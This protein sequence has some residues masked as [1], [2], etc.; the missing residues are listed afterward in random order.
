MSSDEGSAK[1]IKGRRNKHKNYKSIEV[2]KEKEIITV[3]RNVL[4]NFLL[5]VKHWLQHNKEL[6]RKAVFI[7]AGSLVVFLVLLIIHALAKDA[8]GLQLI[9]LKNDLEKT[10][11]LPEG[12]EKQSE[13]KLRL[14]EAEGLCG[15]IW[16]TPAS[17][18]G[19]LL[20]AKIHAEQKEF[21]SSGKA[22][23]KV[24]HHFGSE[25]LGAY[26]LFEAAYAYEQGGDFDKAYE[27]YNDL[28]EKYIPIKKEDIAIFHKG[29]ISY[30]QKKYEIASDLFK[31]IMSNHKDSIYLKK[32]KYYLIMIDA[33]TQKPAS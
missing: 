20:E 23:E 8:Q 3:E 31:K 25:S 30:I 19:C 18:I 6:V 13:L 10:L 14:K 7:F 27:L 28:E 22:Y 24:A 26:A 9:N 29:R 11:I 2:F 1:R 17:Y 16:S 12:D 32:A 15:K 5:N 33:L 4:E 21:L